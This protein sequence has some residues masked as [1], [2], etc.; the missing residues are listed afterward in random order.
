MNF[1]C[2]I[3]HSCNI[4]ST[5]AQLKM[6]VP[7]LLSNHFTAFMF[8]WPHGTEWS[9]GL[10][11]FFFFRVFLAHCNPFSHTVAM[12]K[13]ILCISSLTRGLGKS[14]HQ[15][16]DFF[17]GQGGLSRA[18]WL[19]SPIK[20][21]SALIFVETIARGWIHVEVVAKPWLFCPDPKFET[22]LAFRLVRKVLLD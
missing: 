7:G 9:S 6:N 14:S 1:L 13:I 17:V 8:F 3:F 19:L 2:R 15:C 12:Y 4:G 18:W 21:I 20:L 22:A 10:Q 11:A 16:S 5:P